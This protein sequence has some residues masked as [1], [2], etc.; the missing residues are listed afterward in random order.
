MYLNFGLV[1]KMR[2]FVVVLFYR[3]EIS[4]KSV[5]LNGFFFHELF[6]HVISILKMRQKLV[7]VLLV[8]NEI[9]ATIRAFEQLF[10]N[11]FYTLFQFVLKCLQNHQMQGF[12][13][14][15]TVLLCFCVL[16]HNVTLEWNFAFIYCFLGTIIDQYQIQ[17]MHKYS[18]YSS[19]IET[20][21]LHKSCGEVS[22][23]EQD[24]IENVS[25]AY[26]KFKIV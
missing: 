1:L 13:F 4:A 17:R 21:S 3:N 12:F 7:V 20:K 2:Q 11:C 26:S 16:I 23:L 14:S 15:C 22:L 9:P 10:M 25:A 8:S 5:H 19:I 6:Q 18:F 24:T